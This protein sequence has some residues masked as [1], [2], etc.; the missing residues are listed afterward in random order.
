MKREVG[1]RTERKEKDE[2]RQ[3]IR[4]KVTCHAL[5]NVRKALQKKRIC[6]FVSESYS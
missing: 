5:P 2:G 3:D 1:E 6:C 4:Q